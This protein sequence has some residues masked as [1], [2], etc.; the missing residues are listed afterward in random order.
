LIDARRGA[1]LAF[2]TA[3]TTLFA[4]VLVHRVISAKLLNNYAFLVISL[5]M[6]GF[7][8]SGAL[9]SRLEHHLVPRTDRV[10]VACSAL[11]AIS[12]ILCSVAVYRADVGPQFPD[13]VLSSCMPPRVGCR[14]RSSMQP[15][16]RSVA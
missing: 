8:V 11:F 9:L 2:L 1:A 5:T 16:S 14:S 12:L 6:L 7:A 13:L 4:Q 15:P 10:V 3:G